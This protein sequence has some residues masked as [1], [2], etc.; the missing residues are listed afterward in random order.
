M[1][2][3]RKKNENLGNRK[4]IADEIMLQIGRSVLAV[5]VL[6]AVIVVCV[7][8]STIVSSNKTELTLDSKAA[9]NQLSGFF[10]K[11]AKSVEELAVNP[12][13]RYV[14]SETK[15][16]G[17]IA[18]TDKTD[19]V[20]EYLQG[21]A[22]TDS[23]NVMAVWIA[24]LDASVYLQSNGVTSEDGW[25]IT[26]REWFPCM[27]TGQVLLTEPYIDS[28]TGEMVISAV[29]PV[30]DASGKEV[31]GAVGLD[32]SLA[33]VTEIMSGYKIRNNGYMILMSGAGTI[34]YHP[35]EDLVVQ[36]I[37]DINV[38]QNLKDA[39]AAQTDQ[40][41]RYKVNGSTKYGVVNVSEDT[42]YI[43]ISNLPFLEYYSLLIIIVV[44]LIIIFIIGLV[45]II[46]NIKKSA[47]NLS[48]PILELNHTAQQLAAGDLDVQLKVTAED[49]IGELGDSI[50]ATV[51]R[52]KEYIVYI[53]E[54][55]EVLAKIAD[56]RLGIELKNEYVGEFHKIKEALLNISTSMNSVMH[57]ISETSSMVSAGSTELAGASQMLAEGAEAQAAAV[58][59][60][61]ATAATITEQVQE[62]SKDAELS[63]EATGKVT[64]M[65][66]KNQ[67]NMKQMM[68]AVS[69]IQETSQKV[70]GIIQTIEDI[71]EQTNLL[72]LNASIEAARAGESG[73]G[74][75]VVASEIGNLATE[76][77]KAANITRNLIE[78]SME[79]IN[80]GNEIASDVMASLQESVKAVDRVNDMII[81]TAE[82]AAVQAE[83]VQQISVGIEEISRAV[84]DNSATAEET[85]ATSEELAAQAS[86]LYEMVQKFELF[87]MSD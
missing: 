11:Y 62:S 63:A 77:S 66:E 42:G 40:F 69:K 20:C 82:N 23:E 30:M 59:E 86:V 76:S 3:I 65:M 50:G 9:A 19:T 83:N 13:I 36:N 33:H 16:G 64:K 70:V 54:T 57:G 35:Q 37:N 8:W 84:Q 5:F 26:S 56:G 55:A 6:V 87:E 47:D 61:V 80:K 52:L 34:I 71:A 41:L 21:I 60:L 29:A 39:V 75:A 14:L 45:L 27:Q 1:G 78:L 73:R 74:F 85:S 38:S 43:V 81:K 12:E 46:V 68:E 18:E 2:I 25:D 28:N 4:R 7:V 22:D 31:L 79:E 51:K 17:N 15:P 49:E 67:E 32:I 53:D 44:A 58:E 10:E 48:K 72:S 24:D